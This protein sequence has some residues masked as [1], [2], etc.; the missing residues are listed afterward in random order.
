METHR[1]QR[2]TRR[3]SYMREAAQ[4]RQ[5]KLVSVPE[6]AIAKEWRY[7]RAYSEVLRGVFG[8]PVRIDGRLYV[9]RKSVKAAAAR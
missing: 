1:K 8:P 3:G 2:V 6:I 5:E 7:Q 9:E 4:S